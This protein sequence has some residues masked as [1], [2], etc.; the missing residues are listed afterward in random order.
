MRL[1]KTWKGFF[2]TVMGVTLPFLLSLI[3][4]V[5]LKEYCKIISFLDDGQF[6]LFGAGLF[7]SSYYLFTENFKSISKK[8]DKLLN[9]IVLWALIFCS[10]FYAILY[11]IQII[12]YQLQINLIFIRVG[13]IILYILALISIYR[14]IYV[15]SLKVYPDIDVKKET[16]KEVDNILEQL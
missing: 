8:K 13:S 9:N 1:E 12:N 14:S 10:S 4:I 6:L 16:K 11:F 7:T 2:Y 15:D 3:P 5:I